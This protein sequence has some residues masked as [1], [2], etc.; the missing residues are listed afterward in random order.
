MTLKIEV[1]TLEGL[2]EGIA[3][4]YQERDGKY[5]LP[6]DGVVPKSEYDS[7]NQRLVDANEE[8]AR[9]R[10]SVERWKELGESP[11]AVRDLLNGKVK[12]NED[13]E[14]IVSEIK[15]TYEGKLKEAQG[16]IQDMV[17]KATLADLRGQ[18]SQQNIV[19]QGFDPLVL[20]AQ[21]RIAFDENGN[22]RIMSADG[23]KPLAGSGADG[24]ATVADL[25]KELAASE[26]G[27]MFVKDNG[28]SGSGK[29]PASQNGK[30]NT[31][32]ATRAQFDAMSQRERAAFIKDGGKV[33][34]G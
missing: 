32:T 19:P 18:L 11:D 28:Q 16:R 5:V 9:R 26:M 7:L 29:P 8:N 12:P 22:P 6:V 27:Q 20:V 4:L 13:Q 14:R 33:I 25:A 21:N 15:N 3:S 30:P 1:E 24:Y 34:A 10:R 17:K 2:D 31:Q 23:S